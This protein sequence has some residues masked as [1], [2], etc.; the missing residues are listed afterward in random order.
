MKKA[1]LLS[2]SAVITIIFILAFNISVFAETRGEFSY[3]INGNEATVTAAASSLCGSVVIP[4]ALGGYPVTAIAARCF[5]NDTDIQ[6]VVIPDSVTA[7]GEYAFGGC[8]GLAAV[9]LYPR[10]LKE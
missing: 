5:Y 9:S 8:T 6:S 3:E 10:A 4:E 7:I 1:G 2:V